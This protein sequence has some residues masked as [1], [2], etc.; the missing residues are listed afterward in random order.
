VK[1]HKPGWTMLSAVEVPVPLYGK[2][3][4]AHATYVERLQAEAPP[5]QR[6]RVSL[7]DVVRILLTRA[8]EAGL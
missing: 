8:V 3:A 1:E 7:A 5:G 6:V 4:D 2:L